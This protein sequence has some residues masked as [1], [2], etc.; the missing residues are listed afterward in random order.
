[1]IIVKKIIMVGWLLASIF[2]MGCNPADPDP[3]PNANTNTDLSKTGSFQVPKVAGL[4]YTTTPS[5]G[6]SSFSGK[7]DQD[8]K[9]QYDDGDTIRFYIGDILIG[10]A[11]AKPT[12]TPLDLTPASNASI[13]ILMRFAMDQRAGT[14]N[15]DRVIN[16]INLLLA[17]DDDGDSTDG[18]VITD[19]VHTAAANLNIS[20]DVTTT[21]FATDTSAQTLLT[22]TTGAVLA[23]TTTI[24]NFL[25]TNLSSVSEWG[26]MVWGSSNWN[27]Q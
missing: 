20:F 8:G 19:A 16:I 21:E 26:A 1:M 2:L 25:E 12:I 9:Y 13:D 17:L 14:V 7:T 23:D 6:G 22:S 4:N 5:A 15:D 10:E 11:V 3:D 18:V 24:S 27:N